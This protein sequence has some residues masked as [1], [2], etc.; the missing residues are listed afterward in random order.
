MANDRLFPVPQENYTSDDYWTPKWIFDALAITFDI[1]VAC[2]PEGPHNVPCRAWFTQYDDGLLQEWRGRVWM[3]PP[4]SRAAPW[5]NKFIKHRN[6][7]ALTV[8]GKTK[9]CDTLFATADLM[10]LLPRS[11]Q[12]DQGSIFL[13]T[14]L[15]AY[16][17]DNAEA[18]ANSGI[19]PTR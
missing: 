18:L 6:G 13:P 17:K 16:G 10:L 9:W 4:F 5:V 1:D 2:P 15:W 8:V 12:F 11:M 19:G 14:A 3:N 7:V